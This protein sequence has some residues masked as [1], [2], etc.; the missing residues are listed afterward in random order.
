MGILSI[1]WRREK[2]KESEENVVNEVHCFYTFHKHWP[3]Q[4]ATIVLF[5]PYN[6]EIIKNVISFKFSKLDQQFTENWMQFQ[7]GNSF[8]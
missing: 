3:D 4:H 2:E 6:F 1:E 8:F 7:F 5:K